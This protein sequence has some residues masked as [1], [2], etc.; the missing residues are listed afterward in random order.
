MAD[1]KIF[2][3][4][5]NTEALSN[6]PESYKIIAGVV[7]SVIVFISAGYYLV[8]PIYD[9]YSKLYE[10]NQK[11]ADE[12]KQ[13]ESKLGFI[14]PN[15]YKVLDNI[16]EE[17][18]TLEADIRKL[19]ER[20][21]SKENT[22]SLIYDLEKMVEVNNKSELYDIVPSQ[23]TKASIPAQLQSGKP[24]GLDLNQISLAVTID[25]NYP[26]LISLMKDFE[27]YQRAISSTSLSLT[28]VGSGNKK[29]NVL[30]TTLSLR[31]YVLPEGV[32]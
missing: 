11:L 17:K 15:K 6:I 21:P 1:T 26:N 20:I 19:Q 4:K 10:E 2:G 31:A 7:F 12:N 28:P 3:V 8:Y 23:L 9:E 16:I 29:F 14:P 27:R 5:V 22:A 30:K 32:K 18:K 13:S 24:T 25:S